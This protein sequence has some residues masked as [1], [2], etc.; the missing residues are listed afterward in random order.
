MNYQELLSKKRFID[1]LEEIEKDLNKIDNKFECENYISEVELFADD[2]YNEEK[3]SYEEY[4]NFLDNLWKVSNNAISNF[5]S[6]NVK[7]NDTL[8]MRK[9]NSNIEVNDV[10]TFKKYD[11][12]EIPRP[13]KI[14]SITDSVCILKDLNGNKFK[15]KISYLDKRDLL[16]AEENFGRSFKK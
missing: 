6:E 12:Y 9:V 4:D 5:T 13:Y 8:N 2:L 15:T 11:S 1:S 10:V 7:L 3:I 16:Y 14:I